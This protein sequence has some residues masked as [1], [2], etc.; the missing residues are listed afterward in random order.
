MA[1][2][3]RQQQLAQIQAQIDTARNQIQAIAQQRGVQLPNQAPATQSVAPVAQPPAPAPQAPRAPVA[4]PAPITPPTTPST[5]SIPQGATLAGL[6]RQYNTTVSQLLAVNP[7]ITN[8]DV[9]RAGAALNLPSPAGQLNIPATPSPLALTGGAV[10]SPAQQVTPLAQ[11]DA[12]FRQTQEQEVLNNREQFPLRKQMEDFRLQTQDMRPPQIPDMM[13]QFAQLR[14]QM[15]VLPLESQLADV[16]RRIAETQSLYQGQINREEDRTVPLAIIERRQSA[17]GRQLRTELDSLNL[18][19]SVVAEQLS[20]RV[21]TVSTMMQFGQWNYQQASQQFNQDYNRQLQLFNALQGV[22]EQEMTWQQRQEADA[23]ANL[24]I[25]TNALGRQFNNWNSVPRDQ[26][27]QVRH[28]A[29][30]AGMPEGVIPHL[31][32]PQEKEKLMD[33]VSQDRTQVTILYKDGTSRT[34]QTGLPPSPQA[35]GFNPTQSEISRARGWIE[36]HPLFNEADRQHLLTN[37][38]FFYWVLHQAN[39]E[40]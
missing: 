5:I 27:A 18:E 7:Q 20:N 6:A 16:N 14:E 26:Q 12:K 9:I 34:F 38:T 25:L 35:Q 39:T 1:Q 19:R 15:G 4:S 23:Q 32:Q 29:L 40:I 21:N 31:I 11:A 3:T 2:P 37:P 10:G 24:T 33:I 17:L 22:T 13:S 8:P 30:Q 36:R 28:L